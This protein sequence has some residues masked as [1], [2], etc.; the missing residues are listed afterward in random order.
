MSINFERYIHSVV[1]TPGNFEGGAYSIVF[2]IHKI[3][4][5]I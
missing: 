1:D 4:F 3:Q 2:N 5:V